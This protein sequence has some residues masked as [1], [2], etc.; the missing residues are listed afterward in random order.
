MFSVTGY[1]TG[2]SQWDFLSRRP[3]D[4]HRSAKNHRGLASEEA[5]NKYHDEGMIPAIPTWIPFALS[6]CRFQPEK[7][8]QL[9]QEVI[10]S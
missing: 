4:K 10:T 1:V 6:L 5:D 9:P 8:M 3:N 2:Y 7:V